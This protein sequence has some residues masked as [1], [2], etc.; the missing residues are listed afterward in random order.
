MKRL[1]IKLIKTINGYYVFDANYNCISEI[2][3][4]QYDCLHKMI[5]NKRVNDTECTCI[6]EMLNKKIISDHEIEKI[7]NFY[8]RF[9]DDVLD[10]SIEKMTLQVTQACNLRCSYCIY[11]DMKTVSNQRSHGNQKMTWDI[12]KKA[13]DFLMYHSVDT[14]KVNIG[15]YGG[16][17]LLNFSLIKKIIQYIS[18]TYAGKD[19]SYAITT[20][21]TL[22]TDDVITFF[23]KNKVQLTISMD[24]PEEIHDINRRYA[25]D[26][27]GSYKDVLENTRKF[28]ARHPKYFNEYV[29]LN[30]VL[31]PQFDYEK[32]QKFVSEGWVKNLSNVNTNIIDDSGGITQNVYSENFV[33]KYIYCKFRSIFAYVRNP[34]TNLDSV[35]VRDLSSIY[36]FESRLV[37]ML[38]IP[39]ISA[40]SGPCIPGKNR[41]FVNINGDFYPCER[42]SEVSENMN[43]GSVFK[44]FKLEQAAKLLNVGKITEKQC[45]NCW[46]FTYCL[47]CAKYADADNQ[48]D[49]VRRLSN[50]ERAKNGTEDNLRILILRDEVRKYYE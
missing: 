38:Y 18:T 9:L 28:F 37:P 16:E 4:Y 42:V 21:G 33:W 24:G 19:V 8:T 41:L 47:Q 40:P 25:L 7:E 23:E 32:I 14:K 30:M 29:G 17:P 2:S 43:I 49:E 44:G 26:G 5:Q 10:R 31:D 48:L 12:A 13:V 15:F 20:N 1:L 6:S 27:K 46:N 11:S 36:E 22:L 3:Q 45:K 50:C 35:E 39:S 34:N